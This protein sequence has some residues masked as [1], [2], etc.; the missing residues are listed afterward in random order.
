[1][2]EV[3]TRV[4]DPLGFAFD[5]SCVL[6]LPLYKLDGASFMSKDQYG[7]LCTSTNTLWTPQGRTFPGD[8]Y[9]NLG[10]GMS[11][12]FANGMSAL[13]WM[14]V[15]TLTSHHTLIG[16]PTVNEIT[17]AIDVATGKLRVIFTNVVINWY[18]STGA[19][20][21][22]T[23]ALVGFTFDN[24]TLTFYINGVAAGTDALSGSI[25]TLTEALLESNGGLGYF[26]GQHG[27]VI[28]YS[29]ALMPLEVQHNY[30][31]TKWRY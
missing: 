24:S 17:F 19:I 26:T 1:M 8:G 16:Q 15:T 13:L 3:L 11:T 18:Y 28:L 22:G 27:E 21:V 31:N 2:Q 12:K 6:Y 20:T 29:R 7:H 9:I 4:R 14:N 10:T 23:W 5:P 25:G 30:L